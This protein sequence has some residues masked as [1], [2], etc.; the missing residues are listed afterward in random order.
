MAILTAEELRAAH[1][2]I[3]RL[4]AALER[5]DGEVRV[6]ILI[7]TLVAAAEAAQVPL[8][9]LLERVEKRFLVATESGAQ[10]DS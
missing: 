1:E 7:G 3:N 8:E 4:T 5:T 6:A 2:G 10:R 9:E